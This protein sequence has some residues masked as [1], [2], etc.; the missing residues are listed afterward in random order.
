MTDV[1]LYQTGDGG[2]INFVQGNPELSPVGYE[3]AAY[4][5]LLGGNIED[6]GSE[7]TDALQW[8]GNRTETDPVRQYRSRFQGAIQASKNLA[9]DVLRIEDA[10]GLDLAWFTS[11]GV[12]DEVRVSASVPAYDRLELTV[13]IQL[14]DNEYSFTFLVSVTL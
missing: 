1:R 5:S 2:E 8:W 4:L 3:T 12:A 7:S 13:D 11:E 9:S 6:N 14:G 10:A